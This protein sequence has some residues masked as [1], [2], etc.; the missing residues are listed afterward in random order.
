MALSQEEQRK[1]DERKKWAGNVNNNVKSILALP[2]RNKYASVDPLSGESTPAVAPSGSGMPPIS[3]KVVPASAP[4][5]TEYVPPSET[6]A[7]SGA[8]NQIFAANPK[9]ITGADTGSAKSLD[10]TF[11]A[12]SIFAKS[13]LIVKP[14]LRG[15]AVRSAVDQ[16]HVFTNEDLGALYGMERPTPGAASSPE[17]LAIIA[18]NRADA[19]AS[20]KVGLLS[21]WRE[22]LTEAGVGATTGGIKTAG[23][24][25]RAIKIL[26]ALMTDENQKAR[27]GVDQY[28]ADTA[29]MGVE[30]GARTPTTIQGEDQHYVYD[31]K[32]GS[33]KPTGVK[34]P[35][36]TRKMDEEV[37]KGRIDIM[38]DPNYLND[39]ERQSA[40]DAYDK[41]FG[42]GKG[43]LKKTETPPMAGAR[44]A[45]DGNW[46][47]QKD[48][49]YFK[50]EG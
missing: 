48:G 45:K 26:D 41:Q 46:Y 16:G 5:G 43:S 8:T 42:S 10:N 29:R 28:Q 40:L 49:K 3:S 35:N 7:A 18:Q 4:T 19:E 15:M 14:E 47:V 25:E 13:D 27:T 34:V 31:R 23:Q 9:K 39:E 1:A 12:G 44:K 21:R 30:L 38:K 33:F 20:R 17:N 2:E 24:S 50:V 11:G 37:L 22:A 32:T 6:K 36:T